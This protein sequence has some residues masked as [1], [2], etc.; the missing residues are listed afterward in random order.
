VVL[1]ILAVI[2]FAGLKA[3]GESVVEPLKYYEVNVAGSISLFTAMTKADCNNIVFLHLLL[4]IVNRSIYHM[5]KSTQLT[6]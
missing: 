4:F 6:Q 5:M 2:H 1:D 3:V